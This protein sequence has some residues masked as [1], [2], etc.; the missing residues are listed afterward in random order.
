MMNPLRRLAGETA[1]YG[2]STIVA[3][4]VNFFFVPLYTRVLSPSDYGIATEFLAYIAI[5]QVALTLG[6]ETGCFR[7]ANRHKRPVQVFS[8]ALTTMLAVTLCFFALVTLFSQ[9]IAGA[10]GYAAGAACIIYTGGILASDCF[11]AILFAR[12]RFEHK[13][14]K[15]SVFKTVKI[16]GEVVFNILLFFGAPAYFAAHPDSFWL[17]FIPATPDFTYLLFAI[18]L[19]CVLALLLF[20][21][22]ILR[23]HFGVSGKLWRAMMR[24]SLPLMIAGLP[25]VANDFIDRV[26]FRYL[27]PAGVNWQTE[28]GVFQAGVKLAVIMT[29]FVQMFRYAAEPFFFAGMKDKNA[30]KLYAGVMNHFVAFCMVI[31]LFVVYYLDIIGLLLGKDFRA[32]TDIVPVMLGAYVLLG[33]SFNLSMWYKLSGK[34]K[35]AVYIT[36]AGL[37]VTLAVNFFFMPR[38]GYR[39]A[40]WGH[41]LSYL[42]MVILSAWLGARYYPIPYNRTKIITYIVVGVALYFVGQALPFTHWAKWCANAVLLGAYIAFWCTWEK[43][44]LLPAPKGKHPAPVDTPK[45]AFKNIAEARAWAKSNITGMYKNKNTGDNIRISKIAIDKYLSEKAVGQSANTDV[46]LSALL[47]LP[48]LIETAILKD[49]KPD[50]NN[51]MHIKAIHR[52]YGTIKYQEKI[53]TVK[54]TVKAYLNADSKAYSYQV[55]K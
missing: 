15:F 1:I 14:V 7:F 4:V 51:S 19:S 33:I 2:L 38:Y 54:I 49:S 8:N 52:L 29:L 25:G 18:F 45:H 36:L 53:Y 28:L 44:K 3:R 16:L 13:A 34:T 9:P 10:L 39:A 20:I 5:L 17:R 43:L 27:M 50:D 42:V 21:P 6:L 48:E 47:K 41:L 46:H 31:F 26:L 37:L 32:G 22:D 30:P 40:A 55:M 24:Y 11:T 23:M 12:L 35:Y